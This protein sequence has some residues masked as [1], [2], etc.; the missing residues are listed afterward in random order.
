L[1]FA[2]DFSDFGLAI[3]TQRITSD[4][5]NALIASDVDTH[6][7]PKFRANRISHFDFDGLVF[8]LLANCAAIDCNNAGCGGSPTNH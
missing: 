3:V 6:A 8:D 7:I 1:G 2:C 4:E 5:Y